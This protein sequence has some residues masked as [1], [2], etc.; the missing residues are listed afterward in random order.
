[1]GWA[2]TAAGLGLQAYQGQQGLKSQTRALD[3]QDKEQ[4]RARSA[5]SSDRIRAQ[6][7][8]NKADRKKPDIAALLAAARSDGDAGVG[9]TFLTGSGALGQL[10]GRG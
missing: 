4:A 9:S 5:A 3:L 2:I 6:T 1:M 8:I 7:D 10:G